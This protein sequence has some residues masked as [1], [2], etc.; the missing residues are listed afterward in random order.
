[1]GAGQLITTGNCFNNEFIPSIASDWASKR[2]ALPLGTNRVRFSGI[3]YMGND[4]WIDSV[5]IRYV[6]GIPKLSSKV[7]DVYSLYQNYP[8][9]FNPT[10]I[11]KFDIPAFVGEGGGVVKLKVYD[12][13]GREAATLVNEKLKPGTYEISW[14]GSNY[15]S[16]VYF[17]RLQSDKFSETKKSVLLK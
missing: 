11:I 1:M 3:S 9:P 17:Y 5:C 2:L 7:P 15:S 6:I 13:L 8:N 12:V 4:I 14:D 16:G 10:T